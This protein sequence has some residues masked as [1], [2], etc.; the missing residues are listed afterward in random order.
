MG[1][2]PPLGLIP[3]LLRDRSLP[4]SRSTHLVWM[5]AASAQVSSRGF[6][7]HGVAAVPAPEIIIVIN[8]DISHS[9]GQARPSSS[10]RRTSPR[11]ELGLARFTPTLCVPL[12]VV[13]PACL[14]PE[15][16]LGRKSTDP[17]R[18]I[19]DDMS[20][21]GPSAMEVL[22]AATSAAKIAVFVNTDVLHRHL[23]CLPHPAITR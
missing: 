7:Q 11:T 23:A 13:R 5:T 15:F 14:T 8:S 20:T 17:N 19:P 16:L 1:V 3:V 21:S 10:R 2:V 18:H 6:G 4:R 9:R 12:L 22:T